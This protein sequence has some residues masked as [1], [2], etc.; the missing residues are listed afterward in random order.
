MRNVLLLVTCAVV[1][2]SAP[3]QA[4]TGPTSSDME[5][6]RQ[7]LKADRKLLVATNMALTD[8]EAK[9]FWP[10]YDAYQA[11]LAGINDRTRKLIAAYAGAYNKGPIPDETA[12]QLL[13]EMMAIDDAELKMRQGY[14]PK[15]EKALPMVKVARY[16]QIENKIRALVRYELAAG[17][18]LI[19]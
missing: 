14:V 13:A 12:K 10:I 18:P 4:Q 2:V 3:F 17:I 11:D 9:N 15:L 6:L 1:L 8:A 16:L 7:K 19:Q 5:I